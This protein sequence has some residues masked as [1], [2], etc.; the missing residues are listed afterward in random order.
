MLSVDQGLL[1]ALRIAIALC[2]LVPPSG[3]YPKVYSLNLAEERVFSMRLLASRAI[4]YNVI[5]AVTSPL[6]RTEH[7]HRRDSSPLQFPWAE[8]SHGYHHPQG[9]KTSQRH[10]RLRAGVMWLP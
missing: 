3:F 6:S 8:A 5:M 1:T 9:E 7:H 2:H 4:L 10:E